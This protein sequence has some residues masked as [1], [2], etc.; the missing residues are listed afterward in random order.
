[1]DGFDYFS[2]PSTIT[3]KHYEALRAFY[4]E[5]LSAQEVASRFGYQLSA[6]YSLAHDFRVFLKNKESREDLFFLEKS[7]GRKEKASVD[8]IA[9]T[10]TELRKHYLSVPEI[11]TI[12]DSKG[13]EISEKSIY[14]VLKK[15]GFAR[16]PRRSRQEKMTRRVQDKITAPESAALAFQEERFSS[17][18]AIG[19]LCFLPYL[20]RYEIDKIIQASSYPETKT[21]NRLSSILSFQALKLSNAGRYSEDD[22]WRMDRGLG[23]FAGLNV[24]PKTG[25]FSSYSSRITRRTNIAFLRN[26]HTVWTRNGLLSDSMNLDFSAIP[27]WGDDSPLENNG[28]GKWNKALAS[29]LAVVAQ[30]PDSGILDYSDANPRH[31]AQPQVVL[32][33]L[34]FYRSGASNKD[35][36]KYLV[37]D[38]KFT[39]YKNLNELNRRGVKFITIRRRGKQIVDQLEKVEKSQWKTIRVMGADGKGRLLNAYEEKVRIKD[40]DPPIRQ[41]AITGHGKI[42]PALIITNDDEISREDLAHKYC[43]RWLV[44]KAISEQIEFF[45]LNRVSSSMVIKVDFDLTMTVLAHNLYRLMAMNLDGYS[46]NTSKSLFEKFL[47]NGGEIEIASD[48]IWIKMKKKRNLPALLSEM[49]KYNELVY[50]FMAGKKLRFVGASST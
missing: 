1:M 48:C 47:L 7:P 18:S 22:I 46:H 39:P 50:P 4:Y 17:E 8:E 40:Y 45:H 28:S 33:F 14:I 30:D 6:F 42:K 23:L 26:L 27:Y 3:Q 31:A 24:L 15:E 25:W 29:I 32:E 21:I 49:E 12:L 44:E 9:R 19:I 34:D 2:T 11:K 36:L 38:S 43:R 41:L 10:I 37:F 35:D 5:K 20:R 16:L 13:C